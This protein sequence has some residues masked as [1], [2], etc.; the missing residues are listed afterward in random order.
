VQMRIQKHSH[1]FPE[2]YTAHEGLSIPASRL[3]PVSAIAGQPPSQA[4][5]SRPGMEMSPSWNC[6]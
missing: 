3:V 5:T 6:Q 1:Q 2:I 4:G